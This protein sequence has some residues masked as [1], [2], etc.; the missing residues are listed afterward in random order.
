MHYLLL[1]D[2]GCPVGR[3]ELTDEKWTLLGSLKME[4]ERILA[5]RGK[6]NYGDTQ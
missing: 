4:R 1:I 5:E 2:S 3:A 6:Q